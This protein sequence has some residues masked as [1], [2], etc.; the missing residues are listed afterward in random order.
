ML[1]PAENLAEAL[2]FLSVY[3][4]GAVLFTSR[5]FFRLAE[6]CLSK[7]QLRFFKCV[8]IM[9][10]FGS[11]GIAVYS[12]DVKGKYECVTVGGEDSKTR[13]TAMLRN[14][15]VQH[16]HVYTGYWQRIEDITFRD[17]IF[18]KIDSMHLNV[19]S[20]ADQHTVVAL[21]QRFRNIKKMCVRR[22]KGD[23]AA[24]AAYCA[25]QGIHV[26]MCQ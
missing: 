12:E 14:A 7:F 21:L 4:L 16:L 11:G 19:E 22:V 10:Q 15:V 1:L 24:I 8:T 2:G 23:S 13:L 9:P 3:D 25:K 6:E 17:E 26:E 5:T 20:A 18:L